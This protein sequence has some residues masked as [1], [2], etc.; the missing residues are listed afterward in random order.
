MSYPVTAAEAVLIFTGKKLERE[1]LYSEFEA[2]LDGFVPLPEQA[3]QTVTAVF[4]RIT[5]SHHVS[6]AVFFTIDFDQSGY[7]DQR[8][9]VP[10][11]QLAN[12]A[13]EG[14]DMGVG[15]I[16]LACRSQCP[17]AWHQQQLWDP[18]MT[19][20]GNHLA[21]IKRA[22]ERNRLGL[23]FAKPEPLKPDVA[24]PAGNDEHWRKR[25]A[26]AIKEQRLRVATLQQQHRSQMEAQQT[27]SLAAAQQYLQQISALTEELS[28]AQARNQGLE[29]TIAGQ[30]QKMAG[31]REYFEHKLNSTKS[32]DASTIANLRSH[33]EEEQQRQ[34]ESVTQELNDQLQMRDIELM[35]RQTQ[36]EGLQEEI[37]R[38]K[39]DKDELL[40]GSGNN[41]LEQ[42]HKAGIS[43]VTFQP[44]AGHMT[45]PID[46][47]AGFM[48][49]VNAY[50]ARR[51]K[52]D[53]SIF[54]RWKGH[55]QQPQCDFEHTGHGVCGRAVARIER[56]AEFL[57]GESDRCED[58]RV[59]RL[60]V[61]QVA[62]T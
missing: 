47:I 52:V 34:L 57:P 23:S 40:K 14:P 48:A 30:T 29:E 31:L 1:L 12:I 11:E 38:L 24:A 26:Q 16:R 56:P 9:N 6:A 60:H 42:L 53:E 13:G 21:I 59:T 20:D 44:G 4:L 58:H 50:T 39:Q 7:P 54:I 33:L 43:F 51:C 46:D 49:D 10:I 37:E 32:A 3:G 61:S 35:Y 45:L 18:Q 15:P 5:E 8:W 27:E 19:A 22:L 17:I 41:L 2:V 36:I 55:Y 28:N 62:S 25:I